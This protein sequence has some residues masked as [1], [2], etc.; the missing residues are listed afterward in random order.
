MKLTETDRYQSDLR[1][2][3]TRIHSMQDGENKKECLKLLK[4]FET[5]AASIDRG[6]DI[7]L[8]GKISPVDLRQNIEL[9]TNIRRDLE[10]ILN[11][12]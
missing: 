11:N 12:T 2:Y 7:T 1:L 8:Y 9:M 5:E 10:S 6:H 3:R 4:D